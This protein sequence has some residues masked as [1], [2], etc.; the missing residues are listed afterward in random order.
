L[1]PM[2]SAC[3][4][5]TGPSMSPM[6]TLGSPA[7]HAIRAVRL[8]RSRVFMASRHRHTTL[9]GLLCPSTVRNAALADRTPLSGRAC[10]GGTRQQSG[11]DW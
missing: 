8:T 1:A 10:D 4:S 9:C 5:T 3:S 11:P 2:R 6:A 7:V